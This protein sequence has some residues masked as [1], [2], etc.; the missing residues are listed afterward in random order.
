MAKEPSRAG[1]HSTFREEL[2]RDILSRLSQGEPLAQICRDPGMPH[3]TTFREWCAVGTDDGKDAHMVDGKTL[4]FAYARARQDGFDAIASE[5][6]DIMDAPPERVV[7]ITGDDRSESRIDGASVQWA[8]AR[9]ELR[10]KLLAKW[11]PKRYGEKLEL[12][13]DADNP[14]S[15]AHTIDMGKM[16]EAFLRELAA[17]S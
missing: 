8:K 10:L 17:K 2:A 14:L 13:G 9:A 11:D 6:L 15:H 5:A 7:T 3:P 4:S 12:S 16:S 1:R